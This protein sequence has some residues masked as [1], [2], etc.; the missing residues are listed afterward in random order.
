M[1]DIRI[2]L[3]AAGRDLHEFLMTCT[4]AEL[5]EVNAESY[6]IYCAIFGEIKMRVAQNTLIYDHQDLYTNKWGYSEQM[7]VRI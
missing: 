4:D 2:F 3:S 6:A 7:K 1:T 5:Y